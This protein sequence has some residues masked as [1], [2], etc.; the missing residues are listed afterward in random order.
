M[1]TLLLSLLVICGGA[2]LAVQAGVNSNLQ[3]N[4][5]QHPM[6]ASLTSFIIGTIA[7]GII[8]LVMRVPIPPLPAKFTWWHWTGGLLGAYL[9][10][11]MVL[12]APRFGATVTISLLLVGQ[13]GISL[14]LDHFG[15]VGYAQKAIT[16]QRI[17]GICLIASGVFF[18][19]RF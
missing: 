16:W 3:Q 5:A 13:L 2:A 11:V 15:L 10:S 17:F 1:Q 4:W 19:R 7:L 12:I 18:I 6:L 9:I 8:V 14:L